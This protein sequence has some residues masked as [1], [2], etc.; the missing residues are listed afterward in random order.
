MFEDAAESASSAQRT[1]NFHSDNSLVLEGAE[2]PAP[3][4]PPVVRKRKSVVERLQ[5]S[6]RKRMTL[7]SERNP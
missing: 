6:L 3:N 2:K 1:A 4:I 5:N 7:L